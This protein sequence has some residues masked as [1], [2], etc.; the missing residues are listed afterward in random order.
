[1]YFMVWLH[2]PSNT[3]LISNFM[4]IIKLTVFEFSLYKQKPLL[5]LAMYMHMYVYVVF[6][7]Y[8]YENY[9]SPE[10]YQNGYTWHA[11]NKLSRI[12]F[13]FRCLSTKYFS[14]SHP[15]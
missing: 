8:E 2:L 12:Y 9:M 6:R 15:Q 5:V 13:Y 10:I 7:K 3:R 11:F 1:M 4:F 14:Y